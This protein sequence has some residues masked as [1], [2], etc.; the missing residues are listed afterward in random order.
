MYCSLP[1]F[2]YGLF[3]KAP[4]EMLSICLEVLCLTGTGRSCYKTLNNH[5]GCMSILRCGIEGHSNGAG[6]PFQESQSKYQ[7]IQHSA[8]RVLIA[9]TWKM[10]CMNHHRPLHNR[11]HCGTSSDVKPG[12]KVAAKVSGGK[13]TDEP[14]L[15]IERSRHG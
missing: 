3:F 2:L 13:S 8:R 14:E 10:C 6:T 12:E 5:S 1:A 7:H 15:N 11:T 9:E 4:F